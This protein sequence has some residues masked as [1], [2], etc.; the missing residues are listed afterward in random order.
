MGWLHDTGY[1][2]AYRHEGFLVAANTASQLDPAGDTLQVSGGS[3][4]WRAGCRCGWRGKPAYTSTDLPT[5]A[6]G[7]PDAKAVERHR[8]GGW[9]EWNQHVFAA[10]PEL[11]LADIIT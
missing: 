5:P 10:V 4:R 7:V 11:V 1:A 8:A 6:G 3:T 2:P 9:T